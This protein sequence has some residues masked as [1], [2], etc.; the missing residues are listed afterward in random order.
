MEKIPLTNKA[1]SRWKDRDLGK[2]IL[3]QASIV[4]SLGGHVFERT[5]SARFPIR[6][7]WGPAV[8]A[9]MVKDQ[10]KA[11]FESVVDM[12]LPARVGYE[13]D[14]ILGGRSGP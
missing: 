3:P 2:G 14:A 9:E 10:S 12:E 13:V 6:K 11:A 8:P 4:A 7:L 1:N 5:T